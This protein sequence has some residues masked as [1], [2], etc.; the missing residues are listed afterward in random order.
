VIGMGVESARTSVLTGF[1]AADVILERYAGA[2]GPDFAGYAGHVARVLAF[3]AGLAPGHE[4][5]EAVQIAGAFHDL[6]IWT[7]RSWDYLAPS[8]RLARDHLTAAGRE[9]LAD[10]VVR[11]ILEHHKLLP[12]RGELRETVETF[13]RADLADLS[14]GALRS[15]LSSAYVREVRAAHPNAGFHRRLTELGVR[16][17]VDHP[18]RPLPM[19]HW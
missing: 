6:G 3:Y 18:L 5:P 14:L 19:V 16:W 12:Y 10:E 8:V 9:D 7:A 2:L 1:P 17:A 15:G 11:I 4:A 13:R